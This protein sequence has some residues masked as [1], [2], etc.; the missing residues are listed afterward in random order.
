M[1]KARVIGIVLILLTAAAYLAYCMSWLY[2][3]SFRSL[4]SEALRQSIEW[5]RWAKPLS[6]L[7][8]Q[9]LLALSIFWFWLGGRR[10]SLP[11]LVKCWLVGFA[12]VFALCGL[13]MLAQKL[14]FPR[15]GIYVDLWLPLAWLFAASAFQLMTAALCFWFHGFMSRR[16]SRGGWMRFVPSVLMVAAYAAW[17][18]VPHRG[19]MAASTLGKLLF[20]GWVLLYFFLGMG[21]WWNWVSGNR[22]SY[23]SFCGWYLI[24]LGLL[25]A[26]CIAVS[27]LHWNRAVF[28]GNLADLASLCFKTTAGV[29]LA[30]ICFGLRRLVGA[31]RGLKGFG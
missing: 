28:L 14:F 21:V 12:S 9:A 4:S 8:M 19:V 3:W 17:S 7:G 10:V 13:V 30:G 11:G 20:T 24:H 5:K 23:S 1:K 22:K 15:P 31:D 25:L 16:R 27:L 2:P 29:L 26:A 18:A 6:E